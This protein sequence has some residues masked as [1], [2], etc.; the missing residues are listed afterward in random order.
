MTTYPYGS[1]TLSG[2]TLYGTAI[3]GGVNNIG[4]VFSV[5]LSGVTP[6]ILTSFTG[7]GA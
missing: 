2:S 3:N 7:A 6:T 4:A 5:P 1:L